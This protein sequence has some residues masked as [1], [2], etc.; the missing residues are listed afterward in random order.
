M[1]APAVALGV[2]TA[3]VA[4]PYVTSAVSSQSNSQNYNIQ[5]A[6]STWDDSTRRQETEIRGAP[7]VEAVTMVR[8][9]V[10][11]VGIMVVLLIIYGIG[12]RMQEPPKY[13]SVFDFTPGRD[14]SMASDAT[15][16]FGIIPQKK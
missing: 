12:R 15:R 1:V 6:V 10:I 11:A 9:I 3:A 2:K 16:I 8:Y 7:P 14:I 5:Q 4:A 13:Q